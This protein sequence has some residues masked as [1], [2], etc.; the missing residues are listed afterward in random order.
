TLTYTLHW[1]KPAA[2]DLD[3]VL[4]VLN[5]KHGPATP[6]DGKVVY[7]GLGASVKI[8]L[9]AGLTGYL[10]LWGV[11]H[12]GN[13]SLK[14]PRTSVGLAAVIPLRPLNGSVVRGKAPLLT[15]KGAKD[16]A[17]YNVQVFLKGKRVLT[18]WPSQAQYQIPKSKL[19]P[20]TYVWYVWPAV[21][22]KGSA[23]TF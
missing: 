6:A 16:S 18:A 9:R 19:V 1:L 8:K 23:P 4:V 13:A 21:K 7:K 22:G 5:L 17:Y 11:D 14:P 10:A 20:G 2:T 3:H 12:S 15:W